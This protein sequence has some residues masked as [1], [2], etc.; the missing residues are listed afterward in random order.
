MNILL[1]HRR[2]LIGG[3]EAW[4]ITLARAL[5]IRGHRCELFF[6]EHGPM[7][8]HLPADCVAHFGDLADCLRLVRE[9]GFSV[10]HSSTI[11]WG[12]GVS[13]VCQL[14]ARLVVTAHARL[15]HGFTSANCDAFTGVSEWL[16]GELRSLTGATVKVIPNGIDLDKFRPGV[17]SAETSSPIVAWVG[18]GD[19]PVYKRIDKFAAVAPILRRAGLR[20]WLAEPCGPEEVEKAL[21]GAA[22][23]LLPVVEFWGAVTGER[24]PDFYREIAAS[25]GCVI[26]TSSSE[27]FG[28]ALVEAQ[29]C[30]CPAIGPAVGGVNEVIDPARGGALY[31]AEMEPERLADLTLDTLR[32]QE[33]MRRRREACA[34]H[35]RERFSQERMVQDYLR[36]YWEVGQARRKTAA[37]FRALLRLSPLLHYRDYVERCWSVGS[38]QYQTSQRLAARREWGLAAAAAR[39][40]LETCP[41][42]YARPARIAHLLKTQVRS[43]SKNESA[44]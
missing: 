34:R 2:C 5:R 9:R 44:I 10:V 27:G 43:R 3:L 14:G 38:H 23:A 32:D 22:R 4:M 31:P 41:T 33:Q 19:D 30:G 13:A 21:P 28:L 11:D 40:S 35:A 15:D 16:A 36:V 42:L 37:G 6:F 25:G 39:A 1:T 12:V 29:A 8:R 18:R 26:S 24:M 7:E 20:I 17:E